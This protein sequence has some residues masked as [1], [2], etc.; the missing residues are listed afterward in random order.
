MIDALDFYSS[1]SNII[2][3]TS[4]L[5]IDY[6]NAIS[7]S[8]YTAFHICEQHI[9]LLDHQG[10]G[11]HRSLVLTMAEQDERRIKRLALQ[12][13][14]CRKKRVKADYKLDLY[15]LPGEA[16]QVLAEAKRIYDEII[17]IFSPNQLNQESI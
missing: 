5:E 17:E 4:A 2:G 8:Y 15:V 14:K 13:D 6:R 9:Q 1:I 7:R 3:D 16:E 12:L 11:I 10:C